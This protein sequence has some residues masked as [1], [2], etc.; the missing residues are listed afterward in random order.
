MMVGLFAENG[1]DL[2]WFAEG[3]RAFGIGT[4]IK[5]RVDLGEVGWP[6]TIA[7][8]TA[9]VSGFFPALRAARLRPADALRHT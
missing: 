9:L 8:L 3:L 5:P 7:T 6:I 4:A 1:L 2:A